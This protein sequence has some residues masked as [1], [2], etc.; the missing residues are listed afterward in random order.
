[1]IIA[2]RL[3]FFFNISLSKIDYTVFVMLVSIRFVLVLIN[4]VLLKISIGTSAKQI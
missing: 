2:I 1:M 3:P 4:N